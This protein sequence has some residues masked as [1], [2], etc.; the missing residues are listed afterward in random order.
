M[1]KLNRKEAIELLNKYVTS[2]H[3]VVHSYAVEAV[4]RSLAKVFEPEEEN[5]WAISGLLHDLD[6]DLVDW[7]NDKSTHGPKTIEVLKKENYG[8]EKLYDAILAHNP[9]T[10][11]SRE[12]KIEKAIYAA[13]PIT[14]FIRATTLV[15]PDQKINKVKLSSIKK[16]MKDSRFAAG[17]DRDAM[18]SIDSLDM[19]FKEFSKLSL[20]AMCEISDILDL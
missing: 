13:D 10:G 7:E 12:E 17:A 16:R 3:I 6:N 11:K 15:Y 5:L 2:N 1:N 14:G 20:D 8:N 19:S 4:M 9:A 18:K